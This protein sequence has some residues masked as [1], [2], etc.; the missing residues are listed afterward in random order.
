MSRAFSKRQRLLSLCLLVSN[1]FSLSEMVAQNPG[2]TFVPGNYEQ[3][4]MVTGIIHVNNAEV[5]D[6]LG[7]L[8]AFLNEECRGTNKPVFYPTL[9]KFIASMV[10]YGHNA[11][12]NKYIKFRY[13][14]LKDS[15][16]FALTDSIRFQS[17]AI[18]GNFSSPFYW[19]GKPSGVKEVLTSNLFCIMNPNQGLTQLV[20]K[21]PLTEPV[22]LKI[23]ALNGTS[24]YKKTYNTGTN[25]IPLTNLATGIYLIT[26]NGTTIQEKLKLLVR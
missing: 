16:T 14:T 22:M 1:V 11:D 5:R 21:V 24:C 12:E 2:W 13:Y 6:T 7:I 26:L 19:G 23:I 25:F 4:M 17:D 20:F 18:I 8:G 3:N 9:N 10:I 15:T